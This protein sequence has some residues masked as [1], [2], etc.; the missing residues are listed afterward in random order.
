[1]IENI[2]AY[3]RFF[4]EKL[5]FLHKNKE[6]F[7]KYYEKREMNELLNGYWKLRFISTFLFEFQIIIK[8]QSRLS[9][10]ILKIDSWFKNIGILAVESFIF[11]KK[12]LQ[13]KKE[14]KTIGTILSSQ[15]TIDQSLYLTR[16]KIIL[17]TSLSKIFIKIH[18][19]FI[20]NILTYKYYF[21]DLFNCPE[22]S[23][24][25]TIRLIDFLNKIFLKYL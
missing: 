5:S 7:I 12:V 17:Y 6:I 11:W 1:M 25:L 8:K 16:L 22:F 14:T 24:N 2:L 10:S 3:I 18:I 15:F 13:D 23:K 9:C 20:K 4:E 19:V 21:F